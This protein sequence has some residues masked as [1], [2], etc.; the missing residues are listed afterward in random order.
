MEVLGAPSH[1]EK[2]HLQICSFWCVWRLFGRGR[3]KRYYTDC[4]I[5]GAIASPLLR[6]W[7]LYYYRLTQL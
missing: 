3:A 1:L 4:F 7:H 2:F 5:G 6:D